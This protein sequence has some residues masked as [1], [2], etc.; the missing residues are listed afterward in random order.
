MR[1]LTTI[2]AASILC[3]FGCEDGPTQTFNPSPNGAGNLWNDGNGAASTDPAS[4]GYQETQTGQTATDICTAPEKKKKWGV[5]FNDDIVPPIG[6]VNVADP[7][8]PMVDMSGGQTWVGLKVEDAEKL[9]C[10]SASLGDAFGDGNLTNA[11]GDNQEIIFEYRVST[12]KIIYMGLEPGFTGKLKF[13]SADG[14][15]N[16]EIGLQQQILKNGKPYT[17]TWDFA[18]TA[19]MA[20]WATELVNAMFATYAGLPQEDN[21]ISS[22]HCVPGHFGDQGYLFVPAIGAAFRVSSISAAQPTPSTIS[23]MD[24]Y[25]EKIMPFSLANSRVALDDSG[26]HAIQTGL[27]PMKSINCD[28]HMGMTYQDLI[29]NCVHVTGDMTADKVQENKLLGGLSHGTERFR[30][31]LSGVDVNFTDAVLPP[32]DIVHDKDL[33]HPADVATQFRVDQG[34]LGRIANDR[35]GNNPVTGGR[36]IHGTG[37]VYAEFIRLTQDQ[38]NAASGNTHQLG[39]PA[40]LTGDLKAAGLLGCTGLEGFVVPLDAALSTD[41][42]VKKISIAY[43]KRGQFPP[44]GRLAGGMKPGHQQSVVCDA[45]SGGFLDPATCHSGDTFQLVYNRVLNVLGRG[46]VANLPIEAQDARFFWRTWA[47]GLVKYLLVSTVT[48][49]G[50][51][52]GNVAAAPLNA[53]D[54]FFDSLGAG[55]FETAEYIDR[56]FAKADPKDV[57]QNLQDI[58]DISMT[59]DV[60]NGI[61]ND[62]TFSRDIFRGETAV[63][64]AMRTDTAKAVGSESNALLTNIFGSPLL[65]QTYPSEK[66]KT[67]YQC[68]TIDGLCATSDIPR[69][70]DGTPELDVNGNP[71]LNDYP[72]AFTNGSTF[73]LGLVSPITINKT[74]PNILSAWTHFP[75]HKDPGDYLSPLDPNHNGVDLLIPW[76]TKQP[77]VG[78]PIAVSGTRDRF[79]QTYQLDFSGTTISANIDYD[80]VDPKDQ[81][82]GINFLAVE[83]TDYLGDVYLCWDADTS[84]MLHARMYT[85]VGAMLDWIS[86][87]KTASDAC[88][89]VVRWSPYNNFPDYITS[90]T[91]GVRLGITQGG[92][93]GR[94]VDTTLFVPGQ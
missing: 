91:Y 22:G 68:A 1:R 50:L 6:I 7:K 66:N 39:D 11:W 89:I 71:L 38:L 93:F 15:D 13:K 10:Q 8:G 74:Y 40:C 60:R 3:T 70:A 54:F 56:R 27:G 47:T 43:A 18:N 44:V 37:Y 41:P 84:S 55:Q 76:L 20:P 58:T 25:L 90:L 45:L 23:Y 36:D 52:S 17:L 21:C 49:A 61:F 82:K 4:Q 16:F 64:A 57:F 35:I 79:V 78:F 14:I 69:M 12:R 86:S 46:K 75:I 48:D 2:V 85:S 87:H 94:V 32:Q 9:N 33:P 53:N 80:F 34:T 83:T 26:P 77:G 92:G 81:S 30:F 62:Y 59:A 42:N 51:T 88:G 31:D 28:L 19:K 73:T 65:K 63:Y 29:D 24:Q 5:L 67:A 72:F